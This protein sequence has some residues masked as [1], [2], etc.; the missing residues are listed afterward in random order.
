MPKQN[1]DKIVSSQRDQGDTEVDDE[2]RAPY[3]KKYV[4]TSIIIPASGNQKHIK[5]CVE[6]MKIHTP[7]P[8]EIVFINSG[9]TKGT[10]KWLKQCMSE[11]S[12]YRMVKCPKDENFA[13][14]YNEGIKAA[15]GDSIV[16]MHDDVNV[17]QGWF[18]DM[19]RLMDSDEHIGVVGPMTNAALGIQKDSRADY[20]DMDRFDDYA[21][22][23]RDTNQ[24][25]RT[26][27][28]TVS[29]CCI[30]FRRALAEKIGLF[31]ES[32]E[33]PGLM[34]EDF[35]IRSGLE[36]FKN[37]IASGVFVQHY[38]HHPSGSCNAGEDR[39][40]FDAKWRGIDA[41]TLMGKK[42]YVMNL[43]DAVDELSQKGEI[44]DAIK[45][46]IDGIGQYPSEKRIYY[47]LS[48]ILLNAG[49][50]KEAR[51]VLE[52]IH[53]TNKTDADGKKSMESAGDYDI[54]KLLLE[55]YCLEG[56]NRYKKA[57]QCADRALALKGACAPALNLKGI[58]AYRE[59]DHSAAEGFFCRAID[60]DPGYGEPRTNLGVLKLAKDQ[61]TEAVH[62]LEKG[63][64][65]SPDVNDMATAFHSAITASGDFSKGENRFVDAVALNP[66]NRNL[67]YLLIDLFLRQ[68]KYEP[69][70]NEIEKLIISFGMDDELISEA[71]EIRDKIGPIEIPRDTENQQTLS[72][73]M[74]VK[75]EEEYLPRCLGSIKP[76]VDEM[77]IVDTGSTDRTRDIAI[78]FGAKVFDFTWKDDFSEARNFS[79]SKAGGDW[80]FVLD[81]DEVLSPIDYRELKESH[82]A[83]RKGSCGLLHYH[84][85]LRSSDECLR[86]GCQR[87]K[88]Q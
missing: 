55:G 78:I 16:I 46:L 56:M 49:R 74:I 59:G 54:Q 43:I 31:D 42:L 7:Q 11:N 2:Q 72:L 17:S 80:I 83:P 36:G 40:V 87:W 45:M 60:S 71:L 34:V 68:G 51:E 69:A 64:I 82:N 81:A 18:E 3:H 63:F 70:L 50:F 53:D 84:S 47:A 61:T 37:I 20:G 5:R 33:T 10:L 38:D 39:K 62:L 13:R 4:R 19:N 6:N 52:T 8:Y 86:M 67:R 65:L 25:R 88:V 77:I 29:D 21:K 12:N 23:F 28:R 66:H 24:Y 9:A 1:L 30:M 73:C 44:D 58:L 14:L 32:I 57:G 76:V 15:T 41:D 26:S 75:D 85:K 48:Q 35:C 22:K 27:V 79:L